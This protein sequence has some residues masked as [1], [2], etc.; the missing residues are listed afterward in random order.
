MKTYRDFVL[1]PR[2]STLKPLD[3]RITFD[4]IEDAFQLEEAELSLRAAEEAGFRLDVG[5]K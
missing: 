2:V 5:G 1:K 3:L 4:D